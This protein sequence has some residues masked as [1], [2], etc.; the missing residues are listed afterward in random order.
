MWL[1]LVCTAMAALGV[2]A[3]GAQDIGRRAPERVDTTIS[4]S[5]GGGIVALRYR[6]GYRGNPSK[7]MALSVDGKA[8][9]GAGSVIQGV[10]RS[11][12]IDAVEVM[13]CA[14]SRR[15]VDADIVIN[16]SRGASDNI[17]LPAVS[18]FHLRNNKLTLE[19]RH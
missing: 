9:P 14:R 18:V 11:R 19:D 16:F 12:E 15:S 8:V 5:C 2:P 13:Y 7:F 17:R 1:K 10:A 6:N 4:A 3:A